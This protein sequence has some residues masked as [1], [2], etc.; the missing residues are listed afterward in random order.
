VAAS[1]DWMVV[2]LVVGG[3]LAVAILA[4]YLFTRRD[5]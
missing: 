5:A 2:A 3:G 4:L 1:P